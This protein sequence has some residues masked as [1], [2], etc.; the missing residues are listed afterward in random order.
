MFF[1][2]KILLFQGSEFSFRHSD[3]MVYFGL[4]LKILQV[5]SE[6]LSP[7]KQYLGVNLSGFPVFIFTSIHV[8][9]GQGGTY[10]ADRIFRFI[11]E[12][13]T[14]KL[15]P[16]GGVEISHSFFPVPTILVVPG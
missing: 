9:R 7:E 5:F 14:Q 15:K 13:F 2:F 8:L 16:N 11:F 3:F 10:H 4:F 1:H 12:I 6:V